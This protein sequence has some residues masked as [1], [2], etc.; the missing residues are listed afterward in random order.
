MTYAFCAR[1]ICRRG[2][3]RRHVA[4]FA[5]WSGSSKA[6]LSLGS[7]AKAWRYGKK[8]PRSSGGNEKSTPRLRC[9][10]SLARPKELESL[11]FGSVDQRSI[12]LS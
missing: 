7:R 10:F 12:Q 3:V 11:T 8:Y 1:K 6:S 9:A 2:N 4:R 5:A